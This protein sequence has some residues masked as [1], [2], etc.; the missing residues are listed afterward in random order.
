MMAKYL[1]LYNS[2]LSASETMAQ[3]TPEQMQASMDEW[4]AWRDE[5]VKTA[6]FEFGS[7]LQAASHITPDEV[8]TSDIPV[9]GY[10]I[11]E[12]ESKEVIAALLQTHP[13]LKRQGATIDVL[14][15][16]S[17]PGM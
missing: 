17:M 2:S 7:P 8:T 5:A 1:I 6:E 12:G 11:M 10:S 9:S 3:A 4:L 14:E 16:L 15:M 13:H